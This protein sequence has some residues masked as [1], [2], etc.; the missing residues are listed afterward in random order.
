MAAISCA[1]ETSH[2][3]PEAAQRFAPQVQ[4]GWR[5]GA[6]ARIRPSL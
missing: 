2:H 3:T 5:R 1:A 6:R 4:R